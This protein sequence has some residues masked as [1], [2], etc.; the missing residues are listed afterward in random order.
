[1]KILLGCIVLA[2]CATQA[3]EVEVS[4][5]CHGKCDDSGIGDLDHDGSSLCLALR[6]NGPR[7]TA[8][9][10]AI[11]RVF[12]Q[13]GLVDAVAGGSSGS[14]TAFIVE[15]IEMNPAVYRCG[16]RGCTSKEAGER[17]AFL[18]K[19]IRGYFDVLGET[20]EAAQFADVKTL[21]DALAQRNVAG[22][23]AG[24]NPTAGVDALRSLLA[25]PE[26][27]DVV[28][29]EIAQ[30]LATS[31]DV[32]H[33]A[34][35]FQE[36]LSRGLSF[37]ATSPEI[38][39]RPG[40][41]S[42]PGVIDKVG[43]LGTFY[44]GSSPADPA[45]LGRLLDA[46]APA[47]R[48]K[49][50]AQASATAHDGSTCGA[51]FRTL[52]ENFRAEL[53]RSPSSYPARL[54]DRVG[55]VVPTLVTTAVLEGPAVAAWRS[56]RADYLAA[57]PV[58]MAVD[59]QDVGIGYFGA[60]ED[61][62]QIVR[63]GA[64]RSDEKSQKRRSLGSVTWR[65]A[66]GASPA[67]P[68][69]SRGVELADGRISVGGWSDLQPTLVLEDLGC[70]QIVYATRIGGA[71]TF[72][73]GITRLLGITET[74]ASRLYALDDPSS[75]Y[76]QSLAASDAVSCAD[77]DRPAAQDLDAMTAIGYDAPFETDEPYFE[78][79]P[80]DKLVARTGLPGCTL[81]VR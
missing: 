43:R 3:G 58:R 55:G 5:P 65:V 64:A 8:H 7:I 51:R 44:A 21:A 10:G 41:L 12:E 72:E 39:V 25:S 32:V 16:T 56:A 46:C 35:D 76:Y 37:E 34:R 54:D 19:S 57:R 71:G 73:T 48:G 26:L 81:G 78:E 61:L 14:I 69:L 17:G 75:S 31:P 20:I 23:L 70:D 77:W 9:F 42:F 66:L 13:Y 45:A 47:A 30:V 28:N 22:L 74:Q 67:E 50:W 79:R 49:S 24:P 27:R 38:F 18:M 80:F 60:T 36:T 59:F 62:G 11:A 2:A 29:P 1:M 40:A 63:A 4:P 68:G 6:G 33:H 52:V 53:A 15:S